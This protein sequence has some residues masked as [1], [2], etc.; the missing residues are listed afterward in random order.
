MNYYEILNVDKNATM[1]EIQKQY[2]KLAKIYHPDKNSVDAKKFIVISEAYDILS[3]PM[4]RYKYDIEMEFSNIL[5]KEVNLN[6]NDDEIL[7]LNKYYSKIRY[8][9]EFR[10]L[11]LLF[12]NISKKNKK[13]YSLVDIS[14]YKYV[15]IKNVK[16]N[17]TM[18]LKFSFEDTY[19]NVCKK[20]IIIADDVVYN[21]FVTHTNISYNF[22]NGDYIFTINIFTRISDKYLIDNYDIYLYNDISFYDILFNDTLKIQLPNN[23]INIKINSLDPIIIP[24]LGLKNPTT[25]MR[26]KLIINNR[27]NLLDKKKDIS[28]NITEH[29]QKILYKLFS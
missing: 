14:D 29:E 23:N 3:I 1:R 20:I 12:N 11:K 10:F 5:N 17:Y 19:L 2:Y 6:L 13:K 18:N 27:T 7:L 24:L 9:T 8:S 21:I 26:G 28:K 16:K 15:D 4:K 25:H 22:K